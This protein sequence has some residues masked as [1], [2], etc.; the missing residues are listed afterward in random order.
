MLKTCN[1]CGK[2]HDINYVCYANSKDKKNTDANKFRVT[3]KWKE[4]SK[5]IKERDSY[6]CKVCVNNLYDTYQ[7]Y[8]YNKLEV[9][10][11][12]PIN[13]AYDKRLDNDNL[14]SLC[15]YHHKLA[16]DKI[17]PRKVLIM[18]VNNA[19]ILEIKEE[20]GNNTAPPRI[21]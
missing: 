10:H 1:K 19:D 20:I 6:L 16:E 8:N 14:I 11:I 2:M 15:C 21:V 13:E 4:K 17:I 7:I 3:N 18:L 12:V 5:E 9:H